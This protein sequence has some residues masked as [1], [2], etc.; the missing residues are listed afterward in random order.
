MI[1]RAALLS[2]NGWS[3]QARETGWGQG[4]DPVIGIDVCE[5]RLE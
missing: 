4:M 2:P 1:R 5:Q 3:A